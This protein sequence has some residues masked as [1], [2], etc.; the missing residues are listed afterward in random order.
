MG[1]SGLEEHR[2]GSKVNGNDGQAFWVVGEL[3]VTKASLEMGATANICIM[4]SR[5]CRCHQACKD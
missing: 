5:Q 3:F 2:I 1:Y 4:D